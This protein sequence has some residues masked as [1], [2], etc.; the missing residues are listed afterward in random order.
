MLTIGQL[1]SYTGV[2]VRAIRHYHQRGLLAKPARDASGYRRYDGRAVVELIR[3]KTLAEAGV[4]LA[5]ISELLDAEPGEFAGAITQIDQALKKKIR[6]LT[7]H[8]HKIAELTGGERL[9]LPPEIVEILDCLRAMGVRERTVQ[10]ER[11]GW[12]LVAALS[13]EL[14]PEWVSTKRAALDDPE[15]RRIYILGDQALDWDPADPR[16][17]ELADAMADWA[18]HGRPDTSAGETSASLAAVALM[19]SHIVGSSPSWERLNELSQK[20]LEGLRG[21]PGPGPA[22]TIEIRGPRLVLRALRASEI[23]EEWQAMLDADPMAIA[24]LPDEPDFRARLR[25]SGR[26]ADGQLDLA[27]DLDGLLIGRIQ[28]FVPPGRALPPGTFDVGIG[29]REHARGRGYGREALALLTGWLFEHAGAEVIEAPPTPRTRR[30]ARCSSGPGGP[31][32]GRRPR[33][34][35]TGTCTGSP[36]MTGARGPPGRRPVANAG[37]TAGPRSTRRTPC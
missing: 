9:F 29:L 34:A 8:R 16:I 22:G 5:R 37:G 21:Q 23:D 3:I 12:I 24:G 10:I 30:C 6:E 4:P 27:I 18:A 7:Q 17:A 33:P 20:R 13:P 2:T 19:A 14:V 26:L 25:Q 32:R 31:C 15:F 11:D 36:G 28:T 1:A 35:A